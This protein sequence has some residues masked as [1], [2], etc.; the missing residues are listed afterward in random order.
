MSRV[1]AREQG[2]AAELEMSRI[3]NKQNYKRVLCIPVW[4]ESSMSL[5]SISVHCLVRDVCLLPTLLAGGSIAFL[6]EHLALPAL[7]GCLFTEI[8]GSRVY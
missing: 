7:H 8:P 2:P 3:R 4:Y 1:F 5:P 6:Q